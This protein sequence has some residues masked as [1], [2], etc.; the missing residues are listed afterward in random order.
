MK[1]ALENSNL[2]IQGQKQQDL[3]NYKDISLRWTELL[4]NHIAPN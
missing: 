3:N 4:E 2:I 1:Y